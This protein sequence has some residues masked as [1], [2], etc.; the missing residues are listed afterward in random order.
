[1]RLKVPPLL[2]PPPERVKVPDS[3]LTIPVLLKATPIVAVFAVV[4]LKVPELLNV[5]TLLLLKLSINPC[6]N[7]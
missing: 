5:P 2:T 7:S 3:T 6:C 4:F 1:V